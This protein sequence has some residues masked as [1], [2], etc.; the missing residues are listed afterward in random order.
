MEAVM[1]SRD[2]RQPT[3]ET[4]RRT[5]LTG[6]PLVDGTPVNGPT[7]E[8]DLEGPASDLLRR[9]PRP[10][11]SDPIS[12]TWATLLERPDPSENDRPVLVQWVSP[13][14]PEPPV[15]YHPTTETFRA[16]E[17]RLTVV[18]DG[19][20][21][22][23]NPGESLTVKSGQE[24][25]FRNETDDTVAFRSELPSIRTVTGLYTAWGLAH[26]RGRDGNG[27]YPGPGLGQALVIAADLYDETT[28]TMA[29]VLAQRFLWAT[30]GRVARL[31]GASGI[32]D[33][34]L[35]GSFW[36]QHVEQ[37]EWGQSEDAGY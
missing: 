5:L 20:S 26:E 31:S 24:H 4:R 28:M 9:S 15:H 7:L 23:L 3:D 27:E 35:D 32:D 25:T 37:P 18:C 29:P 19:E 2:R 8:L 36:N 1:D 34:Y 14:S 33:A 6:R 13:E 12:R 30:V 10:L 22:Q 11:V 21:I 17:G 16:L